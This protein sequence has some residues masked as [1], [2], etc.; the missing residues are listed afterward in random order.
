MFN[1]KRLLLVEDSEADAELLT[2]HLGKSR[3]PLHVERVSTERELRACIAQ[4]V[5]DLILS[6]FRIGPMDALRVLQIVREL[7]P[8][9]PV[10]VVT[11]TLTDE[12]AAECIKRGAIDYLLKDK[13]ERLPSAVERALA[14]K[15]LMT[16]RAEAQKLLRHHDAIVSAS[17]DAI[18]GLA[19][20]ETVTSWNQGAEGLYG[21]SADEAIGKLFSA[22]LPPEG[23]SEL[24]EI[25]AALRDGRTVRNL[26]VLHHRRDGKPVSV[27]LTVSPI[28]GGAGENLGGAVIA[29]DVSD[30]KQL[31]QQYLH[32][33]KMEAVGQLAGG[34]AH[35]FNNLLTVING[36]ADLMLQES[37]TESPMAARIKHIKDAAL[38]AAGLTRQLLIFSRRQ[39]IQPRIVN[40]S[41]AVTNLSGMLARLI[42]ANIELVTHLAP[43][44]P[45][46]KIDPGQLE[47]VI[48]NLAVNAQDAMP[49]GGRLLIETVAEVGGAVL[50]VQDNGTGM[51]EST[52]ARI[53]EPF[54]T[55]KEAG[56][57]TGLGLATVYGIMQQSGGT[58]N[59][60]SEPGNGTTFRI[61][62]P[63][64]ESIDAPREA[65]PAVE[66]FAP[67]TETILLVEDDQAVRILTSALLWQLGYSVHEASNTAEACAVLSARKGSIDLLFTDLLMPGGGAPEMSHVVQAGYDGVPIL[68]MSGYTGDLLVRYGISGSEINFI[69]KPFTVQ[70]LSSKL[71]EVLTRERRGT[72]GIGS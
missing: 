71:R 45:S 55:T 27:L 66:T 69:E 4:G 6:D 58:I 22:V 60:H 48:L 54:F 11:G 72:R 52:R 23:R 21:W 31:E 24:T 16:E 57:G 47:Q 65:S 32:S 53:F 15:D 7:A 5:P 17:D 10:I 33:Q 39:V 14:E 42:G 28:R 20:D 46:V 25:N 59:V 44:L 13:L 37:S 12:I 51:D 63:A 49:S 41:D 18:I 68:Y 8:D 70:T 61:W 19:V 9:C 30:R 29:R 40:F 56:K 26:E 62:L 34:V 67:G 35:D 36:Y 3:V 64:T 43:Q 38:R 50:V 2:I 1:E